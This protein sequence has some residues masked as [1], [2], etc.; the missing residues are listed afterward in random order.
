MAENV[1]LVVD[2]NSLLHRSYHAMKASGLSTR[3]GKPTWAL[4]GMWRL[5]LAAYD[6]VG[7]DTVVVGFDSRKSA[8]KTIF[9]DYKA[10]RGTKDDDLVKQLGYAIDFFKDCGIQVVVV[11]GLEADDILAH[12]ANQAKQMGKR[13]VL[14]TSDRDALALVDSNTSVL[15]ASSGG[16]DTWVVMDELTVREKYGAVANRYLEYAAI[17]GD[18]SDNLKGAVGIG[19]VG[20][21]KI[22]NWLYTYE[23]KLVDLLDNETIQSSAEKDLGSA[24]LKKLLSAESVS[25]VKRNLEL[26]K[27]LNVTVSV[28]VDD[29]V[30][31]DG[32]AAMNTARLWDMFGLVNT[33]SQRVS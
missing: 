22:I 5:L 24:L 26:M 3:T 6:K 29:G 7:A 33:L 18:S 9:S 17:R 1:M 15:R 25:N 16:V 23:F 32:D 21:K 11:E 30:F 2:G 13:A 28:H 20:A 27:P 8:R 31:Y 12:M 19:E 4:V 14:C 10:G